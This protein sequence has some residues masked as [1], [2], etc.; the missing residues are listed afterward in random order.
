M[1]YVLAGFFGAAAF[2]AILSALAW[3]VW[4]YA[5]GFRY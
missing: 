2:M 4:R 3:G 1:A 5:T